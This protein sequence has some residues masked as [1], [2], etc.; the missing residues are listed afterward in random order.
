[1]LRRRSAP[2]PVLRTREGAKCRDLFV[3]MIHPPPLRRR[4]RGGLGRGRRAQLAASAEEVT[5]ERSPACNGC[6]GKQHPSPTLPCAS[7]KGG[8]QALRSLSARNPPPPLR[9]RRRGWL[10]RGRRAQLAASAEGATGECSPACNGCCG[11]PHP[12]PTLPCAS[13]KGGSQAPRSLSAHDPPPPLRRRRRGGS[14]RGRRAQLAA[15]AEEVAGERSPACNGYCGEQHP[16][17][18]LPCASHKG[19]S[20][21][22]RSLSAHDPPPPLRRRRRGGLGRGRRA[23]LA[24]SV[25]GVTGERS[26]ACNGCC[27]EQHPSPTLPCALHKGGSQAPRSLSARNPPPP[28]RR[29]RRGGL[30]RGRRAQLVASYE[31]VTGE[32]TPACNGCGGEQHPSPT[33]P[34]ASHKGGSR[35]PRSLSA[36]DPPPPLRRRCRGGLGRG[37]RA[38]LVAS[39]EKFTGE[40][41]PACNGCC[42]KPHPSPILP[43]ASRKGGSRAPQS[44]SAHA[45][46]PPLRR[47]RR[48]GRQAN[49]SK[50]FALEWLHWPG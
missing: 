25:E 18:P 38:Q 48:G 15:S 45:P 31:E 5:G 32:C 7:H 9:R 35:A 28:L 50:P 23:Q 14:G 19:G 13:H 36:H 6:C 44:L 47:R 21:A 4:R 11:Q 17:P 30:G 40:C 26:P 10:G 49:A 3:R 39:A 27:G 2:S 12:S 33:L 1:L 8:S 24:A 41:S 37:R 20:Q 46:P 16:S 34:C 22:P 43:C 42:G 29:R